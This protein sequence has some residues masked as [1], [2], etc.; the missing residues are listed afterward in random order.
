[1][2]KKTIIQLPDGEGQQLPD[3]RVAIDI[4]GTTFNV[5]ARPNPPNQINIQSEAQLEAALGTSEHI[6]PAGENFLIIADAPVTLTK[7]W[8]IGLGST[9]KIVES[10]PGNVITYDAS[11]A[12]GAYFQP[13]IPGNTINNL[14]M[15][16]VDT[17][18]L[19]GGKLFDLTLTGV[20]DISQNQFIGFEDL[21]IFQADIIFWGA[22]AYVGM[23]TGL[24]LVPNVLLHLDLINAV[25][26]PP[27]PPGTPTTLVGNFLTVKQSDNPG[28]PVSVKLLNFTPIAFPVGSSLFYLDPN[29]AGAFIVTGTSTSFPAN[30]YQEKSFLALSSV[31]DAGGGDITVTSRREHGYQ[32]GDTIILAGFVDANYNGTFVV[33]VAATFTFD[34]TATF[35]ATGTGHLQCNPL[36]VSGVANDGGGDARFTTNVTHGLVVG[37]EVFLREFSDANYNGLFTVTAVGTRT[38]DTGVTFGDTTGGDLDLSIMTASEPVVGTTRF[39][40]SF[41]HALKVGSIVQLDNFSE[42]SYNGTFIVTAVSGKDFD[43]LLT[44]NGTDSGTTRNISLDQKDNRVTSRNNPGEEQSMAQAEGRTDSTID[45]VP[46]ISTFVPVVDDTPVAG[47]FIQDTATERFTVDLSTGLITYTGI[48]PLTSTISFGMTLIKSSGGGTDTATISLF[49][50]SIEQTKTNQ[51]TGTYSTSA[52]QSVAYPGGLFTINPGDTF[53]LFI[54]TS[55]VDPITVSG[56]TVLISQQ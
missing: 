14:F 51:I 36:I 17:T 43:V 47:D 56:L 46:T 33:T 48:S 15:N 12:L 1:M 21:G 54:S 39:T 10:M 55:S 41:A 27:G 28:P 18:S 30:F 38:F 23:V 5:R 42:L 44:F 20:S 26:A 25:A 22:Q 8:R 7:P 37:S 3:S 49:Q 13:E 52:S 24:V 4:N 19:Q 40:T 45:L 35:T 29:A 31:S 9:L 34:V 16:Q 2:A 50:N 11:P 32:I 53:Q 6:I